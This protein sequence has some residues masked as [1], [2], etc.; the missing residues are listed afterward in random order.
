MYGQQDSTSPVTKAV[1]ETDT[2]VRGG[3]TPMDALLVIDAGNTHMKWGIYEGS[4]LRSHMRIP[5]HWTH[6]KVETCLH[7]LLDRSHH[8]PS[9]T[10]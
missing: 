3:G 6:S 8:R 5:S 9:G 1:G 2:E 4:T 7:Q 10:R